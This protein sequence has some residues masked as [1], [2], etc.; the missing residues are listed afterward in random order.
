MRDSLAVGV[1]TSVLRRVV[2]K[3]AFLQ[4]EKVG[5]RVSEEQQA[6]GECNQHLLPH[7]TWSRRSQTRLRGES[8]VTDLPQDISEAY[9]SYLTPGSV[10][11]QEVACLYSC[12]EFKLLIRK[13]KLNHYVC[14]LL[15][16]DCSSCIFTGG[17][18]QPRGSI[19]HVTIL[20]F[21]PVIWGSVGP[22]SSQTGTT[23]PLV[24]GAISRAVREWE[25][26]PHVLGIRYDML[27][28]QVYSTTYLKQTPRWSV[29]AL[30]T[31]VF[32]FRSWVIFPHLP[33]ELGCSDPAALTASTDASQSLLCLPHSL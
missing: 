12:S 17:R 29:N 21:P 10:S 24:P 26:G 25:M 11:R 9:T 28:R 13:K 8:K 7:W 30:S 4:V 27:Q 2:L 32:W 33:G 20:R 16:K 18:Q 19:E 23:A 3:P 15:D 6:D 14:C 22:W 1:C 5:W 31:L